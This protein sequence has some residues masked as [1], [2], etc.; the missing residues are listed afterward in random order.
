MIG[1]TGYLEVAAPPDV[2]FE[3]LADM[4]VLDR[5][6]PNVTR[7]KVVS[8]SRLMPGACFESVIRR[9]PIKMTA[10]SELVS[11]EAGRRVEYTGSIGGF[12]SVDSLTFDP[13][14]AG[15][16]ITFRNESTPPRWMRPL[17]PLLNLVFQRQAKRAVAGAKRY[18]AEQ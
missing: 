4:A 17:S 13:L 18:L 16:R 6:N 14:D 2:V 1:F 7:S 11:A 3:L 12:W 8:G 15:T 5:W 10:R 9:G